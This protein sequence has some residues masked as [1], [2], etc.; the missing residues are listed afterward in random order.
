M[1]PEKALAFGEKN[2]YLNYISFNHKKSHFINLALQSWWWLLKQHFL[3]VS[4]FHKCSGGLIYQC[5]GE[6]G[7]SLRGSL[8]TTI[9]FP[10]ILPHCTGKRKDRMGVLLI[11]RNYRIIK[12]CGG[13]IPFFL[14]P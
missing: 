11:I 5:T 7:L 2:N 8:H 9:F 12:G 13:Y 10:I 14:T 1:Q 3:S 4:M 6:K